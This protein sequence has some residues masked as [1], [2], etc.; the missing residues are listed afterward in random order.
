MKHIHQGQFS[1]HGKWETLIKWKI[2]TVSAPPWGHTKE[3]SKQPFQKA[4]NY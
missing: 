4:L 3:V 1:K 2:L